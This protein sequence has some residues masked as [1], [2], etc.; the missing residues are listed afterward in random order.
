MELQMAV[1]MGQLMA[2]KTELTMAKMMVL[3]MD[4]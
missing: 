3:R 4:I 1:K 2:H